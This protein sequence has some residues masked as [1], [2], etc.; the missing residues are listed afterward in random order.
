[1]S[2]A[3]KIFA[4][5][6]V[7]GVLLGGCTVAAHLSALQPAPV[8]SSG[9]ALV[10]PSV[11]REYRTPRVQLGIDVDAYA[12][13]GENMAASARAVVKYV[14]S[15]HAN[16]I[17]ITFPFFMN[18]PKAPVVSTRSSTPTP[19]ML[20]VMARIAEAHGLYVVFRPLLDETSI[21][22]GFRGNLQLSHPAEWFA[23]YRRF[24]LPYAKVAQRMK[25][26]E[27]VV[28]TELSSLYK[29]PRW[30]P[31]DAAIRRVY[32]GRL[33][34]DSNWYGVSSLQGAGGKGLTE[35]VDAYPAI[36]SHI[37]E[38]WKLYDRRLPRGTVEM[39]LGIAAVKGANAAPYEHNWP[40][41][42]IDPQVQAG[43]FTAACHA[44][45]AAHLG[46]IY[47]WSIGLGPRFPGPTPSYPLNWGSGTAG[48]KAISACFA[49]L[50]RKRNR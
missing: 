22:H 23:S 42:P 43:W 12:Y 27:F 50:S 41:K 34:F 35:G 26:Q 25:V 37:E 29:S 10:P 5:V 17:S 28:G 11:A 14:R 33:A 2:L 32:Y 7:L 48:S 15:L 3:G 20:D 19:H 6:G 39:E 18:G 40:G 47:F 45:A 31:L 38:G 4:G 9:S 13:P 36:P 30:Y 24:L 8:R 1:M 21:D 49:W 16:A 46:G 44:A